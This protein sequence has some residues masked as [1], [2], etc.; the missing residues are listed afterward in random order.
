MLSR[1]W[2][3]R[4]FGQAWH[5]LREK[6]RAES[7]PLNAF[8]TYITLPWSTVLD[9]RLLNSLIQIQLLKGIFLVILVE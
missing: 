2:S 5:W 9:G 7:I 3:V 8:L 6:R 4:G 1:L